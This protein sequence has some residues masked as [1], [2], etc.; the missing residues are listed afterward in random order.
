MPKALTVVFDRK[1]DAK[2]WISKTEADIRI[3]T[4]GAS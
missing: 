2:A 3:L 4:L 1:T